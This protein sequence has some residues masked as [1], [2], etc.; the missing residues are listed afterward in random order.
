MKFVFS[1]D[2]HCMGI[3][4]RSRKDY[5]P[6]TILEKMIEVND[7]AEEVKAEA[8][9]YGGDLYDRADTAPSVAR[10]VNQ[11]LIDSPCPIYKVLGNHTIFAYNPESL[12]R[13]MI[14]VSESAG[15]FELL[16]M[17]KAKY[18]FAYDLVVGITGCHSH[19]KLDKDG[20]IEDY[21]PKR[22]I[23]NEKPV[24]I[25]IHVV[26]GYLSLRPRLEAIPHTVIDSI[27]DHTEA[28]IILTGHEH[29]GF[30]VIKR[31]NNKGELKIFCNPGAL[32]GTSA[33]LEEMDRTIQCAIINIED[34]DNYDIILRPLKCQKP[35]EEVLDRSLIEEQKEK[36]KQIQ[37]F[38]NSIADFEVKKLDVYN[39]AEAIAKQ[40]KISKVTLG[41]TIKRLQ[42]AEEEI[43]AEEIN[44]TD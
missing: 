1:T 15:L 12:E 2:Q 14:G 10:K 39:I 26:H 44:F 16:D 24:D 7:I 8:Q 36:E 42:G 30:G 23:F 4:P 27:L 22:P 29:I 33:S 21:C 6:D 41:E 35:R 43:A 11:V 38:S 3:N 25:H 34:K 40:E 28:D 5:Y 13:S 17:E 9:I 37:V 20:R 31:Y 18:H 19:L 32:G